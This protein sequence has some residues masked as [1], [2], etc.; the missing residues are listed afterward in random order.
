MPVDS[1][2][3]KLYEGMRE[4]IAYKLMVKTFK[5]VT[6]STAGTLANYLSHL[7]HD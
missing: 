7:I 5:T 6:R 2:N 3:D 1:N 4:W